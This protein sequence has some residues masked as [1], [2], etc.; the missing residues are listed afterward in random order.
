MKG[1]IR[2]RGKGSWAIVFDLGRDATGKRRQKWHSVKGTRKEAEGELTRLL[3]EIRVGGYVEPS[4]MTL[5][6]YLMRWLQ[7]YAR[8]RVAP[9]T[10]ER[11]KQIVE[12]SLVPALGQCSLSTL[13]PLHIQAFYAAS[14]S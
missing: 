8:T 9:K 4:R 5:S 12:Q 11:Y 3:N 13:R 2:K 6:D 10:Y 14:L 7:D 1:H